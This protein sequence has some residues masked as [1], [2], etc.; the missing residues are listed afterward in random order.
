MRLVPKLDAATREELADRLPFQIL[1][2]EKSCIFLKELMELEP[3]QS[4]AEFIGA[5]LKKHQSFFGL[6]A[7]QILQW[8]VAQ[9]RRFERPSPELIRG[10]VGWMANANHIEEALALLESHLLANLAETEGV[11]AAEEAL[12]KLEG[13]LDFYQELPLKLRLKELL[14]ENP[15]EPVDGEKA[16]DRAV[17]LLIVLA[18]KAAAAAARW[19]V[20]GLADT[21]R[22]VLTNR[23]SV[24]PGWAAEAQ[25]ELE[26][27][28]VWHEEWDAYRA[29]L[30][31]EIQERGLDVGDALS[32]RTVHVFTG[33]QGTDLDGR[34]EKLGGL[35]NLPV[36]IHH[37]DDRG[38]VESLDP[39]S[40][41]AVIIT[42]WSAHKQ[43]DYIKDRCD[44]RRV[45]H[46]QMPKH[47]LAPERIVLE[48]AGRV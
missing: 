14:L 9:A 13:R 36:E 28:E 26:R 24:D 41:A 7:D 8:L 18:N 21:L 23:A 31:D 42:R 27:L 30:R 1:G 6:D 3:H 11:A 46:Y 39:S 29:K 32:G 10:V 48:M 45:R 33:H 20:M 5:S 15:A 37:L 22:G 17:V 47:V 35:L 40:D 12:G 34:Y 2:E 25:Q 4:L 43:T 38:V 16:V 44:K 19:E